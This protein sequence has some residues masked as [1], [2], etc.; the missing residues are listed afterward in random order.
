[1]R[2]H[3]RQ[4]VAAVLVAISSS[5]HLLADGAPAGRIKSA[6]GEAFVVRAGASRPAAAGDAV[7]ATDIVRTGAGGQVGLV[8]RDDT[9]LT[10]GPDTTLD[11]ARFEFEP[12]RHELS[13]VVRVLQG[14]VSYVSGRIAKLAPEAIRIE[15]PSSVIGVRG[16]HLLIQVQAP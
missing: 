1:M 15:T 14:V 5:V 11:L 12:A 13:L 8:L 9:R 2:T 6:A 10:L 4:A 7:A 3:Q 16:T